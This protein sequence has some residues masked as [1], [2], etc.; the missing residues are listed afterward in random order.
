MNKNNRILTLILIGIGLIALA[1]FIAIFVNG[2]ETR[3]SEPQDNNSISA[4]FCTAKGMEDRFYYSENVNTVEN[5]IK[6]TYNNGSIDKLYYSYDGVYRSHDVV[7]QDDGAFQAK[8]NYYM[9]ENGKK[10]DDLSVTYDEMNTKLHIG[11]Y[12]DGAD[13][14]NETTAVFFFIN[15]DDVNQF[16]KYSLEEV[17]KYYK[18]K[19]FSC[20]IVK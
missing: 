18:D 17:S 2:S 5:E 7:K 14:L 13:K 4:V 16:K 19:G 15:K 3:T 6:I 9:S 10:S 20:N 8:Y 11:I 12:A 1:I